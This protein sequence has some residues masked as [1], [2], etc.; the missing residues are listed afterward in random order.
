MTVDN[1]IFQT[2]NVVGNFNYPPNVAAYEPIMKF[3]RNCP[4]YNA[5]TNC[6]SV[7]YQNFL[8]EVWSTVVSFDHFSST[9]EPEK[10]PLKKFPIKFLVLNRQRP[11]TLNFNTFC[12]S[13]GL[14]YNNGKYVDHP[15]PE[16]VKKELGKIAINPSYLY[17]TPVLKNSF[18]VAW[19]ILF[20]FMIQVLCGNNSSIEQVNS[21]Q[22]LLAYSFITGTEV[23]IDDIIYSDPDPSKVTDIELTAHMIDVNNRRDSVSPP[24]LAAKPKKGKS[25]TTISTL[26][27]S[28]G[29]E[30]SGALSKK[31]NKP[32]SKKP[33][34]KTKVTPPK[35]TEGTRKS[36]PLPEG[37]I[38]HPKDSVGTKQPID[39]EP[40]FTTSDEDTTKITSCSE[41][42]IGDKDSEGNIPP[43]D[44]EP[45]QTIVAATSGT[46][47]KYQ[48]DDEVG[49]PPPKQ[50]QPEQTPVQESTSD[51]SPDLKKFDNIIPLTKR[52]LIKYLR[53]IDQNDKL[54]EAS[55][56]SLDK[57]SSTISDLY[58]G[59]EVI[60][61]LLKDIINYVKD[62][63]AINKK[64]E[65]AT[66]TLAK[67][68]TQTNEIL[69]LFRTFDFST[70]QSIVKNNQAH[71]FKQEEAS[72]AWMKQDTS[73]IKSMMFEMYATFKGQPSL[74][75][76]GSVT[77]TLALTHI[78]ANVEG[79]NATHTATEEPPSH[80]GRETDAYRQENVNKPKQSTDAN[81]EY[82]SSSTY[83]HS[84]KKEQNKKAEEEARLNAINQ[85]KVIKV[86]HEEA[87]KL[88][89]HPKE[90]ITT[91][92]GEVFKKVQDTEHAVVKRKHTEKIKKSLE[93]R[94]HKKMKHM[95][96]EPEV[97]ILRLECNRALPENVLF[98]NNMVI[99]E[100]EYGI[101]FTDEFGDQ[102]FQRWN[103]I[104]KVGMKAL[105]SYLV[106]ASMVKSPENARF[107]MK[108]KKLI[109]EHPDQEKLKLK[110]VKLEAL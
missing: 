109:V 66:E 57:N 12:S 58:K 76:S 18:L 31:S 22:Q 21:I 93:L 104:H 9:D 77:P 52:Q 15:T 1:V 26:P 96:L 95:K 69:S 54:V 41:G 2:N 56:S 80:T 38:A 100:P 82:I 50:N 28:Q 103:D 43:A 35:P 11:L 73:E 53:K 98:V 37:T 79:E 92:A 97:K 17:K 14:S 60:S 4:L 5:F 91:K 108:L 106:V 87:K 48:D 27:K 24:P 49:T 32:K 19:R 29:P 47:A 7:V 8:R 89:I 10:R 71:A 85:P 72:A 42:S 33:P 83:Q 105:V 61:Q 36:Q 102:A 63:P 55:M 16:V 59:L 68:S 64:T 78:P 44:M 65:E 46:T 51:S 88:G 25:Q 75:P 110:K 101:F 74:A 62:K 99:K 39:R 86:V 13:T 23:D 84:D 34:T 6:P 3:L 20:T 67:I 45:I 107:N 90:A 81:T 94:K 30:A 70:L 40:T